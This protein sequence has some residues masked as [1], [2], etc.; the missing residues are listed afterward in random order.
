LESTCYLLDGGF[1]QVM[2]Q[3]T[4][5]HIIIFPKTNQFSTIVINFQELKNFIEQHSDTIQCNMRYHIRY[6]TENDELR[7]KSRRF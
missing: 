7:K 1:I 5:D 4:Y 6:N 3:S 2:Q